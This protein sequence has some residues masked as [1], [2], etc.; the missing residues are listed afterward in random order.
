M[1]DSK[2]EAKAQLERFREGIT[3]ILRKTWDDP[4]PQEILKKILTNSE[5]PDE[6]YVGPAFLLAPP[7]DQILVRLHRQI[8]TEFCLSLRDAITR[9]PDYALVTAK[10]HVIKR[11]HPQFHWKV[12]ALSRSLRRFETIKDFRTVTR[13]PYVF[14]AQ[15]IEFLKHMKILPGPK[16]SQ[17]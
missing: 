2:A 8:F 10:V 9:H 7:D 1:P 15:D 3:E 6:T 4:E 14:S 16:N 12:V 5:C 17:S 11:H 13:H